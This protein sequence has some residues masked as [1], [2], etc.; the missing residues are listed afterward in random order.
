MKRFILAVM[1]L[2]GAGSLASADYIIITFN[3]AQPKTQPGGNQIGLPIGGGQIG[4]PPMGQRGG[5][6]AGM[7][8]SGPPGGMIGGGG[9]P[10]EPPHSVS[11]H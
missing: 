1:F 9:P 5:P 3:L 10:P 2:L 4:I 7:I 8:G 6:P 11:V